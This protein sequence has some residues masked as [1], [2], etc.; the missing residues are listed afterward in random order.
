MHGK[1]YI[2][3]DTAGSRA[4]SAVIFDSRMQMQTMIYAEVNKQTF[5]LHLSIVLL[6][7]SFILLNYL[8][9]QFIF[10]ANIS[11]TVT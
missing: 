1:G 3:G 4:T 10:K 5:N 9:T 7:E 8:H 11:S 2:Y 6:F